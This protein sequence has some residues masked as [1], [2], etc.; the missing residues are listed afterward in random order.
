MAKK[1]QRIGLDGRIRTVVKATRSRDERIQQHMHGRS[2]YDR[3]TD[4]ET[5]YVVFSILAI[6]SLILLGWLAWLVMR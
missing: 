6:L 2:D 5:K 1:Q 4:G 3:S